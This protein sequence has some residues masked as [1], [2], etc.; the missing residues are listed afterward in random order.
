MFGYD[1]DGPLYITDKRDPFITEKN[2]QKLLDDYMQRHDIS[3][4]ELLEKAKN[5]K[6]NPF[7][8][9]MARWFRTKYSH[10]E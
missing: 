3:Y 5:P 6:T 4:K 1:W 9:S 7:S 8:A 10:Y 2:Y